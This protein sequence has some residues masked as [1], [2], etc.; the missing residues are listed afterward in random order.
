MALQ[1]TPLTPTSS[2]TLSSVVAS[3][4]P[5]FQGVPTVITLDTDDV[6][7][8]NAAF[9]SCYT[10]LINPESI[11]F[12]H[13]HGYMGSN[14]V[15]SNGVQIYME[16]ITVHGGQFPTD[17][18]ETPGPTC[19]HTSS[20]G[21]VSASTSST[22][23][24]VPTQTQP[25]AG[26]RIASSTF[27]RVLRARGLNINTSTVRSVFLAIESLVTSYTSIS[28]DPNYSR[29]LP[30]VSNNIVLQYVSL[31]R[32]VHVPDWAQP[33]DNG[34]R[35][36]SKAARQQGSKAYR[37]QPVGLCS[38]G[39]RREAQP[40]SRF[41]FFLGTDAILPES[42]PQL[43]RM[44]IRS[45]GGTFINGTYRNVLHETGL[46]ISHAAR[47]ARRDPSDLCHSPAR[48]TDSVRFRPC[49]AFSGG[50]STEEGEV[51]AEEKWCCDL[52]YFA[53]SYNWGTDS[54]GEIIEVDGGRFAVTTN[55][56]RLLQDICL[57]RP[58]DLF[59]A[60]AICIDQSN[61]A[62]KSHQVQQMPHIY[63]AAEQVCIY[64]AEVHLMDADYCRSD[65]VRALT[66]AQE[67]FDR[68]TR[69]QYWPVDS[70]IWKSAW[71]SSWAG[72]EFNLQY[73]TTEQTTAMKTLF[74]HPWFS[75]A[76]IIQEVA[77][78]RSATIYC[79]GYHIS[80]RVFALMP[81]II[82][83]IPGAHYQAILDIMP[84]PT[85]TSWWIKDRTLRKL[86]YKFRESQARFTHDKI[87]A[88][89]GICTDSEARMILEPDYSKGEEQVAQDA[90]AMLYRVPRY[91]LAGIPL[92][93]PYIFEAPE[94]DTLKQ[95]SK[96]RRPTEKDE[97]KWHENASDFVP[98]AYVIHAAAGPRKPG[99]NDFHFGGHSLG[100]DRALLQHKA[101]QLFS[102]VK[103]LNHTSRF[104]YARVPP[105]GL[106][107]DAAIPNTN[108]LAAAA[109]CRCA[110]MTKPR[111]AGKA[112]AGEEV[113]LD[114]ESFSTARIRLALSLKM[115]LGA[116]SILRLMLRPFVLELEASETS[117]LAK[118]LRHSSFPDAVLLLLRGR[119]LV[120]AIPSSRVLVRALSGN[121]QYGP[122]ILHGILRDILDNTKTPRNMKTLQQASPAR[123]SSILSDN[124]P[125]WDQSN[126]F[127]LGFR[128]HQYL[129]TLWTRG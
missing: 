106:S 14:N 92:N 67:N 38:S 15:G 52:P 93:S 114:G 112:V 72:R 88:L 109:A 44:T 45:I 57:K 36:G 54:R 50:H 16:S 35:Q 18:S 53:I 43:A 89:L 85:R 69:G 80:R 83:I 71:D 51:G 102:Q 115:G 90:A 94:P 120:H 116:Y 55:L 47:R 56:F 60:D 101:E 49:S 1:T 79:Y 122:R 6:I 42:L 105:Q 24:A 23:S 58:G 17:A 25:G 28:L 22:T 2:A 78:A 59:W 12:I 118:I 61:H 64:L 128:A 95:R 13:D 62:E 3:T 81:S 98:L 5:A 31:V 125:F 99:L 11:Y 117:L 100:A 19:T 77:K 32:G 20:S 111:D 40:Q 121:Q 68:I 7:T 76:S 4:T 91:L 74:S 66:R 33:P 127:C 108:E 21:T 39:E 119:D 86:L 70:P 30:K 8:G 103:R 48:S 113:A 26:T 126:R 96:L 123:Y 46:Q 41:P 75:R 124:L 84:G 34:Q 129:Y 65:A 29:Y 82:P 63:E 104:A 73:N 27:G 9:V 87:Y 37:R 10:L 97:G 110:W 107:L